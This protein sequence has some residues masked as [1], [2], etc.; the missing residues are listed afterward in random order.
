MMSDVE[1]DRGVYCND[2][3]GLPMEVCEG[4]ITRLECLRK[5]HIVDD[6]WRNWI[7]GMS[8]PDLRLGH[9]RLL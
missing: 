6:K 1:E 3:W 4:P 8:M 7:G 5:A 9:A 2:T